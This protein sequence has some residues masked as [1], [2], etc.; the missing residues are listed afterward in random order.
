MKKKY[1]TT[2]LFSLIIFHSCNVDSRPTTI[3]KSN[4]NKTVIPSGAIPIIREKGRIIL[5][6]V[7]NDSLCTRLILDNGT[8]NLVLDKAYTLKN[9]GHL[10]ITYDPK[11]RII[12]L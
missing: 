5:P 1:I 2:I 12:I 3:N 8:T 10:K 11:F 7:L 6:V 4:E 9:N